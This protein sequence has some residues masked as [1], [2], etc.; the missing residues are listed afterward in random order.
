MIDP[1]QGTTKLGLSNLS[2]LIVISSM[3]AVCGSLELIAKVLLNDIGDVG[4]IHGVL[5]KFDA[6]VVDIPHLSLVAGTA[7]I[8]LDALHDMIIGCEIE[9]IDGDDEDDG[10]RVRNIGLKCLG[11]GHCLCWSGHWYD[12]ML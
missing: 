10:V 2:S 4:R 12:V 6:D 7:E 8:C 9:A 5:K 11:L 1:I 3:E